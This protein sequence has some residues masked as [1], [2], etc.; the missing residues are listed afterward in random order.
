MA[1]RMVPINWHI[2]LSL[3]E[4]VDEA[5]RRAGMPRAAWLRDAA[6]GK[7]EWEKLTREER[8]EIMSGAKHD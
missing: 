4:R 3:L 5:A 6:R 8:A 1:E 2:P 7:L